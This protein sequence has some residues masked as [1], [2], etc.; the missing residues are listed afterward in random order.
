MD[1]F[2]FHLYFSNAPQPVFKCEDFDDDMEIADGC[3]YHIKNIFEQLDEFRAFELLRTGL[4]RTRY[5][6]VKASGSILSLIWLF[7]QCGKR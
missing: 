5:L 7:L 4:D 1:R 2:P 6:L 3:W